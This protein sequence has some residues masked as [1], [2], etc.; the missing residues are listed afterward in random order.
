[1]D[2]ITCISERRSGR[3]YTDEPVTDEVLDELIRLGTLAA[4]GSNTQ[5]WGFV[6]LKNK[7]EIDEWSDKTKQHLK[8]H[9][10]DF[11]HLKQYESWFGNEDFNVFNHASRVLVIYG[12]SQ[13]RYHEYDCTLAASNIMLAAHSK[14]IGTCWIGF[15]EHMLDTVEFKNRYNVPEEFR[16]VCPMSLGYMKHPLKPPKRRDPVIFYR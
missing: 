15:A 3:A 12:S 7:A 1:M 6:I 14:G 8:T 9:L 11:P 2:I 10:D 5:P 13:A 4:T 16:L